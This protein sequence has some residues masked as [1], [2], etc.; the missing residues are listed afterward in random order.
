MERRTNR[1]DPAWTKTTLG[2][3]RA[4][5][6]CSGGWRRL[7]KAQGV[8]DLKRDREKVDAIVV[9]LR[10]IRESNG[11]DDMVWALRCLKHEQA[12]WHVRRMAR[13]VLRICLLSK[14]LQRMSRTSYAVFEEALKVS[15]SNDRRLLDKHRG[16]CLRIFRTRSGLI[17]NVAGIAAQ[18]CS[19]NA[20]DVRLEMLATNSFRI[21]GELHIRGVG[22]F[23]RRIV[24]EEIKEAP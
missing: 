14:R 18:A 13:E 7:L 12:G 10:Q 22:D 20:H 3:I 9:S 21:T 1:N 5:E 19:W 15:L 6:P 2:E 8:R 11:H 16:K 4:K 17:A 23:V 24:E